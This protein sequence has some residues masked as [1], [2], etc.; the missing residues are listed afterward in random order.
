MKGN[1]AY[2]CFKKHMSKNYGIDPCI[3][4][5]VTMGLGMD[6][7]NLM[8]FTAVTLRD[9]GYVAEMPYIEHS[10]TTRKASSEA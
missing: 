10:L 3:L 4:R 2:K 6:H 1:K 8:K 7:P 5:E 9:S